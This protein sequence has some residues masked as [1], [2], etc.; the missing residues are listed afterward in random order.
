MM[1]NG[2]A[3]R[4]EVNDSNRGDVPA[5]SESAETPPPDARSESGKMPHEPPEVTVVK[6]AKKIQRVREK[7]KSCGTE[8][9]ES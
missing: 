8:E 9:V 3:G 5:T 7:L 2:K 1:S 4:E 6:D